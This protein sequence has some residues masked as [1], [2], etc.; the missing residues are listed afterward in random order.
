[1]LLEGGAD[2]NMQM[3]VRGV[4]MEGVKVCCFQCLVVM[5]CVEMCVV[6]FG[7]VWVPSGRVPSGGGKAG[8][9]ISRQGGPILA[10]TSL[11]TNK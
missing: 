3:S 4:E 1:M 7:C 10:R 6:V 9:R 8:N 2:V 11:G 5:G